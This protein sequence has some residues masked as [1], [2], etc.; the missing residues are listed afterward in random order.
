MPHRTCA[1]PGCDT[2]LSLYKSETEEEAIANTDL[3]AG[4]YITRVAIIEGK[5][6]Q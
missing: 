4:E 1:A 6:R 2:I 5:G 3:H